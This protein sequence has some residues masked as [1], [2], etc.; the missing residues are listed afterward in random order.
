VLE[1][2]VVFKKSKLELCGS[3]CYEL[4]G[5]DADGVRRDSVTALSLGV[6]ETK[7]PCI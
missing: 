3:C 6:L 2:V 1:K 5:A 4:R 7:C